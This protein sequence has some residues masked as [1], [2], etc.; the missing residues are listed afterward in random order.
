MQPVTVRVVGLTAIELRAIPCS[1]ANDRPDV[2]QIYYVAGVTIANLGPSCYNGCFC[3]F[4]DFEFFLCDVL[5][6]GRRDSHFI[7][8]KVTTM[9][10]DQSVSFCFNIPKAI[11]SLD[12]DAEDF[13]A[14]EADNV[15]HPIDAWVVPKCDHEECRD[16]SDAEYNG[17]CHYED[18]P[19]TMDEMD[20]ARRTLIN[21]IWYNRHKNLSWQIE[22]GMHEIVSHAEWQ[23]L[24]Y[25]DIQ[26][27]TVD[28]IW[29]DAQKYAEKVEQIL[30]EDKCGPWT[31]YEWG[32]LNGKLSTLRWV[33]G[34]QWDELDT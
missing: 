21:Q 31:D 9:N 15:A 17:T 3:V 12:F 4:D 20:E 6:D 26:N 8:T 34:Y 16:E 25:P 30:G 5:D 32:M 2:S 22:K 33:L 24:T 7:S 18:K 28:Y 13:S 14:I 1:L 11:L 27:Y 19:R 10:Q 29:A 23:K